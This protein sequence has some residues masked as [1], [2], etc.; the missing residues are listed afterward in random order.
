MVWALVN[1]DVLRD[2]ILFGIDYNCKKMT[3]HKNIR[4]GDSPP[5]TEQIT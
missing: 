4:K 2:F 1:H 5:G 3:L